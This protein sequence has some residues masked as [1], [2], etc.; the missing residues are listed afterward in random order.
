MPFRK[1]FADR[2]ANHPAAYSMIVLALGM[3]T[4][5]LIAVCISV[6]ASEKARRDGNRLLCAA[7]ASDVQ[8]YVETPPT[9]PAGKN[10]LRAKREFLRAQCP[11][12]DKG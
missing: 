2:G 9:T 10:Q 8:A 11:K 1:Y 5:M 12:E 6:E 3:V 4:S 7:I